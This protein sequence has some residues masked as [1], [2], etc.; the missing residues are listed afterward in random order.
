MEEIPLKYQKEGGMYTECFLT[1]LPCGMCLINSGP[2]YLIKCAE[3]E[4]YH[5]VTSSF[6]ENLGGGNSFHSQCYLL[7]RFAD[8]HHPSNDRWHFLPFL[9]G[10][11][12]IG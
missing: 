4:I 10:K 9:L 3:I 8:P 12:F 6:T 5:F 2:D 11:A 7:C 1:V